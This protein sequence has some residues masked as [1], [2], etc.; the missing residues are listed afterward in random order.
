MEAAD[1]GVH[2]VDAGHF[3]GPLYGVDH[4]AMATRAQDDETLAFDKIVG[5]D[6]MIEIVGD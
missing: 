6:L 4:A 1:D 5:C 3:L 2:L